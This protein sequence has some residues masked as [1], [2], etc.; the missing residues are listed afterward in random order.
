M[1]LIDLVFVGISAVAIWPWWAPV[2][3]VVSVLLIVRTVRTPARTRPDSDVRTYARC[4]DRRVR[5]ARGC[6]DRRRMPSAEY[7]MTCT[8]TVRGVSGHGRG[9]VSGHGGEVS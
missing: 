9:P 2:A 4:P 1:R 5:S 3:V 7:P 6:P 8:D